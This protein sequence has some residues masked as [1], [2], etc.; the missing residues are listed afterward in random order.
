MMVYFLYILIGISTGIITVF[1]TAAED[2]FARLKAGIT[3]DIIGGSDARMFLGWSFFTAFSI[4]IA[5]ITSVLI[6]YKAP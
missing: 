6:A 2:E 1:I 4:G 3:S 5:I